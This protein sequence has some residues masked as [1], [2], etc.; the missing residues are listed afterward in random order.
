MK[1]IIIVNVCALLLIFLT[2]GVNARPNTDDTQI[3]NL[4][5]QRINILN[6]FYG[7]KMAFEDAR[8]NIEKIAAD[9][10]L[11]EDLQLM[12][13]FDG[14]DVDQVA[15]YNVN[16][17]SCERTSYGIIKGQVDIFWLMQGENGGWETE[18]TYFYTAE[19]DQGKI[20]LTQLKKI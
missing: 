16:M 14:T 6:H 18:E 20:K 7:G 11:K 9:S 13:A 4:L 5:S 8:N 17:I 15:E 12:K 1:K 3:K 19:D 2:A 10:L